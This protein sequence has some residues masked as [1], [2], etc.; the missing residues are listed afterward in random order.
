MDIFIMS[1]V[2][3]QEHGMTFI[4]SRLFGVPQMHIT[5]F[6]HSHCRLMKSLPSYFIFYC[7]LNRF[8]S[9]FTSMILIVG[10]NVGV[11]V[12]L[13]VADGRTFADSRVVFAF[14]LKSAFTLHPTTSPLGIMPMLDTQMCLKIHGQRC[15]PQDYCQ[16]Q[17]SKGSSL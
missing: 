3:T 15:S 4:Y 7:C 2:S 12:S 14:S 10:K 13:V 17:E 1:Q 8:F 9:P 5:L 16:H 11:T 6:S